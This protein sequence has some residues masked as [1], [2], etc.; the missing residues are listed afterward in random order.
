L[1]GVMFIRGKEGHEKEG[2]RGTGTHLV[3]AE[4]QVSAEEGITASSSTAHKRE[5]N[6]QRSKKGN[7]PKKR[8]PR[9]TSAEEKVNQINTQ[10]PKKLNHQISKKSQTK[11]RQLSQRG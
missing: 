6:Q 7:T 8:N 9:E 4:S 3:T 2:S 5:E 10:F 1:P 11:I